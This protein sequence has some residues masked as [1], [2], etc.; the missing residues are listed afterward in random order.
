MSW[1]LTHPSLYKEI[2]PFLDKTHHNGLLAE[3]SFTG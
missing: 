2:V 1:G 3:V